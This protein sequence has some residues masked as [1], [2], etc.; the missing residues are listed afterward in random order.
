MFAQTA[1]TPH[2]TEQSRKIVIPKDAEVMPEIREG[3]IT[4]VKYPN[5]LYV[6]AKGEYIFGTDFQF[7]RGHDSRTPYFSGGAMMAWRTKPNEYSPSPFIVYPDGKYREFPTGTKTTTGMPNDVFAAS[8]FCEGYALVQRGNMMSSTQ[9]FIDKTGKAVFPAL[10]SKQTGTFGDLNIYPVRE[11]RRLYYNAELKKYGYA[12]EKGVI[13]IKPQFDKAANFSEGLAAVMSDGKWGFI[14]ATGKMVIPATWKLKP[15]RFSEGLAAVRIGDS[16]YEFEMTWI[17]K[18]GKPAMDNKPWRLNEF[19]GGFAWVA[20]G[21]EKMFVMNRQFE[22]VRDLT[23]DFYH[24]GNGF[25]V[26]EFK[27]LTG[28]VQNPD[29]GIDFPKGTQALNQG[30]LDAGD[31]FAPDGATVFKCTDAEGARVNLHAITEGDLM[32]CQLRV[33]DEPRL[34][35]TDV[36]LSCFINQK[37]EIVYF[38]EQGD[39]GFEGM[40]PVQV[41]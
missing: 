37:G 29:W 41:K 38:F 34:K 39:E 9:S 28:D 24:D 25:G 22:E 23:K 6:T 2:F 19:H 5:M 3:M 12:D 40:K 30:G 15:G 7:T 33:K 32:F 10:G 8:G 20:T 14:D 26:C 13:A 35:E 31:I 11:N 1:L 16:E 4:V 17:D 36:Y 27:M 21:C 18:T